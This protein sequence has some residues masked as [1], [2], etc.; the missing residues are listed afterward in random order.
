MLIGQGNK[1]LL[2]SWCLGEKIPAKQ[3]VKPSFF[4]ENTRFSLR[5]IAQICHISNSSVARISHL[6]TTRT[7]LSTNSSSRKVGW[8]RKITERDG[9]A[10]CRALERLQAGGANMT[11]KNVLKESET[12][13]K[14][15]HRLTFSRFL[16]EKGYVYFVARR[17]GL[18]SEKGRKLRLKYA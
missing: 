13:L 17:K 9:R 8:P 7:S 6:S 11:V 15:A 12:S 10:L 3:R 18:V 4:K 2:R 16:N 14:V 5:E 1:E